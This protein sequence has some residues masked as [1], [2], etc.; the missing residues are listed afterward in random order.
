MATISPIYTRTGLN[1]LRNVSW[2]LANGDV[3]A[4]VRMPQYADKS[5]DI[6]GTFGAGGSVTMRGSN[7]PTADATVSG[8]WF[9]LTDPQANA[10][11]KTSKAGE[12]ILENPL[13]ISPQCTA[14]D[15]T[16][17]IIVAVQGVKK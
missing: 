17:A 2:T 11:T 5:V 3:G 15:G 10:I 6:Y 13:W 16:T 7:K 4:A 14:G 9:P 12:Q 1:K 8:D